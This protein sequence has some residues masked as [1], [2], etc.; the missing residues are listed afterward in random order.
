MAFKSPCEGTGIVETEDLR[1]VAGSLAIGQQRNGPLEAPLDEVLVGRGA[2][3]LA[4]E[5][6]EVVRR[7]TGHGGQLRH[8]VLGPEVDFHVIQHQ[9]Q[10]GAV[11]A[12]G[13][14]AAVLFLRQ[15][16]QLSAQQDEEELP[17]HELHAVRIREL[18]AEDAEKLFEAEAAQHGKT[19]FLPLAGWLLQGREQGLWKGAFHEQRREAEGRVGMVTLEGVPKTRQQQ[20]KIARTDDAFFAVLAGADAHGMGGLQQ[21]PG[22]PGGQDFGR[23]RVALEHGQ[24]ERSAGVD[25]EVFGF[26]VAHGSGIKRD[27]YRGITGG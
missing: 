19:G 18:L 2:R 22:I 21:G 8:A 13:E 14:A 4:E 24:P 15:A 16:G 5:A 1:H 10:G 7:T 11:Q 25:Q 27:A 6:Y 20:G 3:G 23:H 17:G 26:W 12:I 9:L